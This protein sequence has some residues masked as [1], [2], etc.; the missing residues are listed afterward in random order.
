V[1]LISK[2]KCV[3][4]NHQTCHWISPD[5]GSDLFARCGFE[6]SDRDLLMHLLINNPLRISLQCVKIHISRGN[7]HTHFLHTWLRSYKRICSAD[8]ALCSCI[9]HAT[10]LS[11]NLM[12]SGSFSFALQIL[13][14]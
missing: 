5:P 3:D 12:F 8:H 6:M 1:A 11:V 4:F 2:N 7:I 14:C 13:V 9:H 10:N